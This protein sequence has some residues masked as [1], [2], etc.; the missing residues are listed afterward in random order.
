M[1]NQSQLRLKRAPTNQRPQAKML[2]LKLEKATAA[3]LE[4]VK[5]ALG[6]D[7][8]EGYIAGWASTPG[9]DSYRDV[10]LPGAFDEAIQSRGLQGPKGIKLLINHDWKSV[11]GAIKVLETRNGRLW[12]EAQ[13]N[14]AISYAADMHEA[15]KSAGGLSFSIGFFLKEYNI[16][17]DGNN[18]D[19]FEL[20]KGDLF[21][22]SIV[23]FPANDECVMEFY[24]SENP[25]YS[26]MG[27]PDL[28]NEDDAPQSL[29]EFEKMLVS[30]GIVKSRNDARLVTLEVKN[31]IKLF[32]KDL[33]LEGM[34]MS[35]EGT[36]DVVVVTPPVET[37]TGKALK[38]DE[39]QTKSIESSLTTLKALF[40]IA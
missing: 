7:I 8:P 3:E 39:T 13:L 28:G 14:L 2:E 12:I 25:E 18:Q 20:V 10:V 1:R 5:K 6:D 23:P 22:V 19:Y 32:M 27:A 4:A 38:A 33:S 15:I 35:I 16:R 26:E 17:Q 34:E 37:Q 30:N 31:A 9:L 11:A 24:K 36:N 29:A 40:T 21:E